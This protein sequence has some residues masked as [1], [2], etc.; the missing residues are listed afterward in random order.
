MGRSTGRGG[1]RMRS[2][3]E[4]AVR[5]RINDRD[6]EAIQPAERKGY[7]R[8]T[9]GRYQE[10]AR[11][12]AKELRNVRV[13]EHAPAGRRGDHASTAGRARQR[14]VGRFLSSDEIG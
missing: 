2:A 9:A 3:G 11:R 1:T 7:N 13:F 10:E 4:A 8:G 14:Q 6:G 12:R 5:V